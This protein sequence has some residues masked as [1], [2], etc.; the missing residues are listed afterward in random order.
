MGEGPFVCARSIHL[1]STMLEVERAAAGE[2][3]RTTAGLEAGATDSLSGDGLAPG[4]L[5]VDRV[6]LG[7]PDQ[8]VQIGARDVQAARSQGLV[9]V[10]IADGCDGELDLIVAEL[11]L[12]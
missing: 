11:S 3:A 10:V 9:A 1:S 12:E 7:E 5:G 6:R 8:A 2:D 4:L